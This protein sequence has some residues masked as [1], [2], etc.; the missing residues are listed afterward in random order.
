MKFTDAQVESWLGSDFKRADFIDMLKDI[1]NGVYRAE[2]LHEDIRSWV[3]DSDDDTYDEYG[4]NTKNSFNT[5]PK[6][7]V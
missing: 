4:V 5:P 6:E 7:A 1:A 2:Q 3:A